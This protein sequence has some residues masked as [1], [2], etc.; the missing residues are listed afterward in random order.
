[1]CFCV[2]ILESGSKFIARS[3]RSIELLNNNS[4]RQCVVMIYQISSDS[5]NHVDSRISRMHLCAR[6]ERN[7]EYWINVKYCLVRLFA[8]DVFVPTIGCLLFVAVLQFLAIPR[9][10]KRERWKFYTG[11]VCAE[12]ANRDGRQ[13]MFELDLVSSACLDSYRS[14]LT[15]AVSSLPKYLPW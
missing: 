4:H 14:T 2:K 1:M 8:V 7:V 5:H 13:N 3:F 12:S 6:T 15:W 10:R 9:R 11:R